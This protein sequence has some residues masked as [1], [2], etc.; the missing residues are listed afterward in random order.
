MLF[1]RSIH[2]CFPD[3]GAKSFQRSWLAFAAK[4][5]QG[6]IRCRAAARWQPPLHQPVSPDG[7]QRQGRFALHASPE[8][9][10]LQMPRELAKPERLET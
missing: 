8:R 1:I 2:L 9:P 10:K 5:F 4:L 6:F 7:E 3:G